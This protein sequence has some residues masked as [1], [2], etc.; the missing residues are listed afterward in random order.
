MACVKIMSDEYTNVLRHSGADQRGTYGVH[1]KNDRND[2]K[3]FL[4]V[5]E[6]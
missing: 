1:A 3:W 2:E 5:S 4:S 6:H